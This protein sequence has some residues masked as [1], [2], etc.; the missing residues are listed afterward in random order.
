MKIE[1]EPP[2]HAT[3]YDV[4]DETAPHAVFF[5]LRVDVGLWF[6]LGA[7]GSWVEAVPGENFQIS[8]LTEIK[9]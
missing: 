8:N 7:N 9:K 4:Y 2:E 1:I 3:H 5:Y 6:I